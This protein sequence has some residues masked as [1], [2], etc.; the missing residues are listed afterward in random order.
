MHY[1]WIKEI[2]RVL[3]P[4]GLF[5]G[6]FHGR[7]PYTYDRLLPDEKSK[8]LNGEFISRGNVKEGSRIYVAYHSDKFITDELLSDFDSFWKENSDFPQSIWCARL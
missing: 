5:I 6:S 3:K 4:G 1:K 2:R 7:T 8:F